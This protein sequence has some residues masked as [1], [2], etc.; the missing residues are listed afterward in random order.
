M[1]VLGQRKNVKNKMLGKLVTVPL[2]LA[3]SQLFLHN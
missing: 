2:G 3:W 1:M